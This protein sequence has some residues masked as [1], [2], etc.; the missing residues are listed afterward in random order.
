M[1]K[2]ASE[3]YNLHP[4]KDKEALQRWGSHSLRVGACTIL[5][6]MGFTETQI[7]H[8]L[9]WRS[10]AFMA[11]LRNLGFLA[12]KQSQAISDASKLPNFL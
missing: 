10:T 11:Y 9:R 2:T 8:L 4:I 6:A 5:Y 12:L 1:Q 3:V 7:Q